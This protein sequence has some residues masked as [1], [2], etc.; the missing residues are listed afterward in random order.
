MNAPKIKVRNMAEADLPS[1]QPLLRQLGYGLTLNELEQRFNLVVK[2]PDHSA[3]VCETEGK[4]VGL[5]HI[6]G[7]PA[8]EKPAEAIIQSIVVDKAYR[9]VGIGNK[10]VAAAELWA[11]EQGYGS[12]AL[13][14]RTDRDDAHAFYSQ[15]DYRA[16]AVAH[17]LQKGLR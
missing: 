11:T 10:L 4:V 12:I 14:S 9:K 7:R 8:L 6:Y 13:Y 3:L 5:L 1:V 15:M 17:L 16:K 2:S